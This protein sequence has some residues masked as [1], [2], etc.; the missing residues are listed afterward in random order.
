MIRN[1]KIW[2]AFSILIPYFLL[3][4]KV[5]C[6]QNLTIHNDSLY[7]DI[8][9]EQ[10]AIRV[11]FPSTYKPELKEK[12]DVLYVLDGEWNTPLTEHLRQF[13]AYGKFIP[14]NMIIVSVP[15][16]YQEGLNMRDRDFT[17]TKVEN[18][19]GSGGAANFISFLKKELIPFVDNKYP[20]RIENNTL[21]GT[22][23]GGLFAI[24]VYLNEPALFK[25]YLT[26]EPSLFWDDGYI[27]KIASEK[28]EGH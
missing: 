16:L 26:V 18:I 2:F 23:L 24:Y 3:L 15:N 9:K 20:T 25:S 5:A 12:F 19:P 1:R 21:Y 10:R 6:T 17:P 13:L 27:N 14:D 22:S 7:S 8:L 28:I 4:S 11:I